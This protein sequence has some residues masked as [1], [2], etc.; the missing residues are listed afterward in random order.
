MPTNCPICHSYIEKLEGE[1]I[2]RCTGGLF[3]NAQK[4]QVITHFAHRRAM[5]IYGLGE[6]LVEQL[7]QA[8]LINHPADLYKLGLN[9]LV[10]LDRMDSKD[11]KLASN[12]LKAIEDS[13][14]SS[15]A[16]LIFALGIRHVGET[17]AKD[18][19]KYF[20]SMH[21]LMEA[22]EDD[23][24]KV[25]DVGPVIVKSIQNF[26]SQAHN[27]EVVEQLIASGINP[28]ETP[29]EK[30]TVEALV[31]KTVVLTGT[32]P[33]LSREQAKLL[34]EEAGA[35]VVGS[36][37]AK[38]NYVL[39]GEAAGSKLEKALELGVPILNEPEFLS[40]LEDVK[41]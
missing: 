28:L 29:K 33:T 40:L 16:R 23:L 14:Q 37:S 15:L 39:A 10:T 8:Q 21:A 35:K 18:L 12:L 26:F 2:A 4:M 22:S 17:T 1:T 38:T 20:G 7:I 13:K 11:K 41:D 27:C 24:L 6:K 5:N 34:L 25:H 9:A 30:R 3:C 32:L 19:A 31:G 36:V